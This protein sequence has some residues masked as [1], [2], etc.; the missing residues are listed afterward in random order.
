MKTLETERLTIRPMTLDDASFIRRLLNEPTW[1]RYIGDKGVRTEEDAK[2]YILNGPMQ[3]YKDF[4]LGLQ[5][6]TISEQKRPI[7][8]CGLIKRPSLKD[9]D[10]GY[11]FLP[12]HTNKGYAYEAAVAAVQYAKETLLLEKLVAFTTLD[13]EDSGKLLIKLG[14]TFEGIKP[15]ETSEV[16][17]FTKKLL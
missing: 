16:K 10:L 17:W 13:N 11:A 14:F 12:E 4:S 1:I 9:V 5:V 3:M 7:G 15:Y 2:N 6:V 8:V